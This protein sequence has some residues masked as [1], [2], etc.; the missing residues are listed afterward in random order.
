MSGL[1]DILDLPEQVRKSD[2]VIRLTEGVAHPAELLRDYAITPD[3]HA[4]YDKA[5]GFVGKAIRDKRSEASYV[6]GSFGAGKS[7]FMAVLSLMLANDPTPWGEPALHDLKAKH[8][9]V[10]E[11]KILRLHFHMV[12]ARNV[13]EKVFAEYL[14]RMRELHPDAPVA[15]LFEDQALFDNAQELRTELGDARFF[16]I[17]NA[18]QGAAKGWGKLGAAAVWDAKTFDAARSTDDADER[19]R[20]F[21][22]LVKTHFKAF[23]HGA[24]GYIGFDRGLGILARHAARLGYDAVVLFLDELILW[25]A[26]RASEH[27]WLNNEVAK[28]AKLVEA[29]DEKRDIPI[30]SFVARQRD[31]AE[32]VGDQFAGVDAQSL[33]DTLKWWEGRFNTVKLEDRNLPTIVEKRVVRPKN[34]AAKKQLDDAFTSMQRGLGPAWATLLGESGDEKAFR[35]VYPFTPALIEALVAMSHFLQRERTALKVLVELLVEHMEDFEIGRAV[36]VGDLFDVLAGG[37]EPMDG[38]MKERFAAAKRL[39]ANELLPAI[40]AA[41]QTGNSQRCQRLRDSHPVALGCSNCAEARC[42][43]DNRLVKTMLLSALVPQVP[44]LRNLTVSRLVQL[45]HGTL[46]S[47]I[48]GNEAGMAVSRLRTFAA[49]IGKLRVGDQADPQVSV[50]LEGV[51]LKPILDGARVYDSPGA[52]RRKLQEVLFEAL[53]LETGAPTIKHTEP[54]RNC[55]RE[56]AVHFGNVRE[57]EDDA[58]LAVPGEEFRIIIDYPFDDPGHGPQED[59]ARLARFTDKGGATPTVVWLPSFFSEKVSKDLAELVIIDKVLEGDDWKRTFQHLRPDDQVRAKEELLNLASQKRARIRR[60]LEAAYDLKKADEGELDAARA[61]DKHFHVLTPGMQIRGLVAPRFAE[62]LK[63]MVDE[64]LSQ[65]F[66]RHPKFADPVTPRRL[67]D[68]SEQ[69]TKLYEAEGHRFPIAGKERKEFDVVEKLG[70]ADV[71]DSSAA[72]R[73]LRVQE[74]D[75]A[76]RADGIQTPTVAQVRK[77]LDAAGVRGLTRAV[78]DLEVV[79]YATASGRELMRNDRPLG[80]VTFGKLPDDAELVMTPMPSQASWQQAVDRAGGLFGI[81]LGGRALHARNLR[82][83]STKLEEKRAQAALDRASEIA[84]LLTAHWAAFFAG[85]PPRLLTARAVADLVSQLRGADAIAQVEALASIEP[86]TSAKAMERHIVHARKT[87]EALGREL[88]RKAFMALRGHADPEA[89]NVLADLKR[90]LE[91]DQ[92]NEDLAT[93]LDHLALKAQHILN[94]VVDDDERVV[95]QGNDKGTAA[96]IA[97]ITNRLEKAL[98]D[99]GQGA[100]L[101]VTWRVTRKGK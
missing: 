98:V 59:E 54:W 55:K 96:D 31:I 10:K 72:L 38:V 57:M 83:L 4:A 66:P 69:V 44:V 12:G 34:P 2:F 24:T 73:L 18:G 52:R 23:S 100:V 32:M 25:L 58:L 56:G 7:H 71:T 16:A 84:E 6:H 48:P 3:I 19:G 1:R 9:W 82:L 62:A 65:R 5:L 49:E 75:N 21:S 53:G 68:A 63:V 80:D 27:A 77:R 17:L 14:A 30:V 90:I 92:V 33:R 42:R 95:A 70:L 36:P 13:E 47:P 93:Q 15:P 39:Y 26:S 87:A 29:Q 37:E 35:Q 101:T 8:E 51:D 64:L 60:A 79:A 22:A 97:K 20:L 81:S 61:I 41:N 40:H 86:Q 91:A 85:E 88:A 99:A 76:L 28:L 45:N 74:M 50:V 11:R 43:A 94:P 89:I 46:K 78:S 67:D